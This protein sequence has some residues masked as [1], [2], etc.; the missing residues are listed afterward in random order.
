[1]DTAPEVSTSTQ[2]ETP[3]GSYAR[4]IRA[5]SGLVMVAI[6]AAL[7]ASIAY[8]AVREPEY[9]ASARLLIDPA[10]SDDE[11]L[12]GLPV[13]R[14][15]GDPTRTAQT[16][17]DLLHSPRAAEETARRAG[18]GWTT[19]S[20]LDAVTV[21][22]AGQSNILAVTAVADSPAGAADLANDFADAT[23]ADRDAQLNAAVREEIRYS[24]PSAGAAAPRPAARDR[25]A[26]LEVM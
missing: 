16:A 7:A 5:H 17:A 1:M 22:P 13:V 15:A 11:V 9:Q 6:L 20:V 23:L 3:L 14:D 2:P 10:S 19:Q 12:L 21:E 24:E 26:R 8:V 18:A 25:V 4:A